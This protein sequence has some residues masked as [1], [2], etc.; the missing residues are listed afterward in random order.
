[1]HREALSD[2][3]KL[4]WERLKEFP[5]FYLAGGTALALQIGHRISVDFDLFSSAEIEKSLLA[6]VKRIYADASVNVSVNSA[7]ELTVFINDIKLTFL[8]YP[9]SLLFEL[10]HDDGLA[11][12]SVKE[13]AATKAYTI[14]RRGSYKDYIDLFFIIQERHAALPEIIAMAAKKYGTAFNDR[15]FLEQLVYLDDIEDVQIQQLRGAPLD[16]AA[17]EKFFTEEIKKITLL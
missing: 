13:I 5:M 10:V 2:P 3:S 15:L 7:D 12:L 17:I 1:M 11:L 9:F 6:K 14:G 8:Y 4:I 16:K